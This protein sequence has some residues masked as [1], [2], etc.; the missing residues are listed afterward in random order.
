MDG[1]THRK[2]HYYP[3]PNKFEEFLQN[4]RKCQVDL[5]S[6]ENLKQQKAGHN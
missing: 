1:F 4:K 6:R 5:T 2:Q 3:L